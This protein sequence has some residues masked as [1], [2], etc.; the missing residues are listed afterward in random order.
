MTSNPTTPA[1]VA[2]SEAETIATLMR[3]L[4]AQLAAA[5]GR[6]QELEGLLGGAAKELEMYDKIAE[7]K[8][9]HAVL[10]AQSGWNAQ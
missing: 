1:R 3:E 6:I 2:T 7:L 4:T 5:H 9:Q 8:I 10:V